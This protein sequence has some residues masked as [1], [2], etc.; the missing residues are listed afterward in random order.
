MA[1]HVDKFAETVCQQLLFIS[2]LQ[3]REVG[4]DPLAADRSVIPQLDFAKNIGIR[5]GEVSQEELDFL[6]EI[7]ISAG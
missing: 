7:P 2:L 5:L 6:P 3:P 4:E 1:F